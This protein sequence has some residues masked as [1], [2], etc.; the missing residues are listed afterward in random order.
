MIKAWIT[1]LSLWLWQTCTHTHTH[2]ANVNK[3]IHCWRCKG[4]QANS[5]PQITAV[6]R[7]QINDGGGSSDCTHQNNNSSHSGEKNK[8]AGVWSGSA[9]ASEGGRLEEHPA[10]ALSDSATSGGATAWPIHPVLF[11]PG[12]CLCTCLLLFGGGSGVR[13]VGKLVKGSQET[14][15]ST[16]LWSLHYRIW[17]SARAHLI[18]LRTH[19]HAHKCTC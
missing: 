1:I 19:T 9:H 18:S 13:R 6:Q 2:K 4:K 10:V 15:H 11:Y 16:C 17:H 7:K 12:A 3:H 5:E 14:H 8:A